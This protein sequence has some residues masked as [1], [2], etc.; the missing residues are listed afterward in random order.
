METRLY[1]SWSNIVKYNV[2][3]VSSIKAVVPVNVHIMARKK[4]EY[5][6]RIQTQIDGSQPLWAP[7][8]MSPKNDQERIFL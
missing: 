2:L 6:C 5:Q 3:Q 1:M 7:K 4:T 8:K